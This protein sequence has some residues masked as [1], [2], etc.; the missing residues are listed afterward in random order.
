QIRA[1]V[2]EKLALDARHLDVGGGPDRHGREQRRRRAA[3]SAPERVG[4]A[5]RHWNEGRAMS[6]PRCVRAADEPFDTCSAHAGQRQATGVSGRLGCRW[7]AMVVVMGGIEPPT[8][9]L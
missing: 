8:C 6:V 2:I 5:E 7:E 1:D 4:V 9:G 3:M